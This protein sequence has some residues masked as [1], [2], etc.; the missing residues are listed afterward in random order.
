MSIVLTMRFSLRSFLLAFYF[1]PNLSKSQIFLFFV[2]K[3]NKK[4]TIDVSPL[5][6]CLPIDDKFRHTTVK[7]E[8]LPQQ[9]KLGQCYDA[10]H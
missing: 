10:V 8:F 9:L 6:V 7:V 1:E 3:Q 2:K 5:R 4:K